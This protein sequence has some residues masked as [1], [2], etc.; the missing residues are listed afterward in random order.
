MELSELH[1]S[2]APAPGVP[3]AFE[4][5]SLLADL[6]DCQRIERNEQQRHLPIIL[7][8][9]LQAGAL[10]TPSARMSPDGQLA[11]GGGATSPFL[12]AGLGIQVLPRLNIAVNYQ[13]MGEPSCWQ[14]ISKGWRE[15]LSRQTLL[16]LQ[17]LSERDIGGWGPS[18][19]IGAND[20]F[21]AGVADSF[22]AVATQTLPSLHLEASAGWSHGPQ[23]GWFASAIW[24]PFRLG[25]SPLRGLSLV[26]EYASAP[27]GHPFCG[28]SPISTPH[29]FHGGI[30]YRLA[31]LLQISVATLGG[32]ETYAGVALQADLGAPISGMPKWFDRPYQSVCANLEP[33][34]VLRTDRDLALDLARALEEHRLI[35]QGA[36]LQTTE[37]GGRQ[38]RLR[39]MNQTYTWQI[40]V[41]ERLERILSSLVPEGIES[42]AVVLSAYGADTQQWT[43]SVDDLH[44]WL[45][46]DLSLEELRVLSPQ[47]GVERMGAATE[48]FRRPLNTWQWDVQPYT[49]SVWLKQL[50]A[51]QGVY[52]IGIGG[53]GYLFD[54][55]FYR[56]R[57]N[58]TGWNGLTGY[59]D[60]ELLTPSPSL[61]VRSDM[62]LYNLQGK[63]RLSEAFLQRTWSTRRGLYLRASLGYYD[64]AFAGGALEALWYPVGSWWAIGLEAAPLLK[65]T[66]GGLGFTSSAHFG[67]GCLTPCRSFYPWQL[68]VDLYGTYEPWA[69]ELKASFGHFIARDVG[70]RL[71]ATRTWASGMRITVWGSWS[72]LPDSAGGEIYADRGLGFS[73][74]IDILLPRRSRGRYQ[75][76]TGAVYPDIGARVTTGVPLYRS[77]SDERR[78]RPES[79]LP[80]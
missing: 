49:E 74:P 75:Y 59:N 55:Y 53:Q 44:R 79:C 14:D 25:S 60:E 65:R 47:T 45:Q 46:R 10:L 3:S 18:I 27:T 26:G 43:W 70:L 62:I 40:E 51:S 77:L 66:Y 41:R 78:E 15:A 24:S 61:V 4:Q 20:L 13:K 71:E 2:A 16:K 22:Y 1:A 5:R 36:W 34:G 54:H 6:L 68:F 37:S 38:L 73:I 21:G 9:N 23:T 12:A 28:C 50:G 72:R 19:S 35:L 67:D 33:I 31:D 17:L 42:V 69:L 39:I 58:I 8:A 63:L 57:L 11:F 64:L 52:G 30:V 32:Q 7:N 48:L 76:G 29:R 80:F 56:A